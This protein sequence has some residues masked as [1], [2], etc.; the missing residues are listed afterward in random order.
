MMTIVM[1]IM[2]YLPCFLHCRL[3]L[4]AVGMSPGV[5]ITVVRTQVGQHRIKNSRIL[6]SRKKKNHSLWMVILGVESVSAYQRRGRLVIEI[7]RSHSH[8]S[9]FS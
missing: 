3:T 1:A 6:I 8:T 4:P 9:I 5:R 7:E 2:V